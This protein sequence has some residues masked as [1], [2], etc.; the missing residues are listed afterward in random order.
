M[1]W[2]RAGDA[3][4]VSEERCKVESLDGS[5][6]ESWKGRGVA[7]S[8]I[9]TFKRSSNVQGHKPIVRSR[10]PRCE[11]HAWDLKA[12]E[13][14]SYPFRLAEAYI[15]EVVPMDIRMGVFSSYVVFDA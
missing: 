10:E 15:S 1:A 7:K 12:R 9:G 3:K 14:S 4:E 11:A 2:R 6:D 13:V 5:H 8:K